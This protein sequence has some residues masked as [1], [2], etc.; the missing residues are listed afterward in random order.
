MRKARS[1]GSSWLTSG[2]LRS[3][4]SGAI[5]A[6]TRSY[7]DGCPATAPEITRL[8]VASRGALK[9][10]GDAVT[11]TPSESMTRTIRSAVSSSARAN[12]W[13]YRRS[14]NN[15]IGRS[16]FPCRSRSASGPSG[17][18]LRRS[19][20]TARTATPGTFR[21]PTCVAPAWPRS[22]A[23]PR[24]LEPGGISG[25]PVG[26]TETTAGSLEADGDPALGGDAVHRSPRQR[27]SWPQPSSWAVR[28]SS[29]TS[30][31]AGTSRPRAQRIGPCP[32]GEAPADP[33]C[34]RH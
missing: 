13:P 15:P 9:R 21:R 8:I 34:A 1:T 18:C 27:P 19:W 3:V 24:D 11:R 5:R 22:R 2:G 29:P 20:S 30:P 12:S 7:S 33:R 17:C 31:M 16:W 25:G 4:S 10:T 23:R 14:R 28:P 26:G 6:T 32:Q